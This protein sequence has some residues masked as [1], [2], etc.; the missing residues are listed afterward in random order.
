M[1]STCW[2]NKNHATNHCYEW[3][4]NKNRKINIFSLHVPP[5]SYHSRQWCQ[6]NFSGTYSINCRQSLRWWRWRQHITCLL[7]GNV[8]RW[9]CIKYYM[10]MIPPVQFGVVEENLYRGSVPVAANFPYLLGLKLKVGTSRNFFMSVVRL[11]III[12]TIWLT[13]FSNIYVKGDPVSCSG[14]ST[15]WTTP[16]YQNI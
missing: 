14:E 15:P 11:F 9:S 7:R 12:I 16:I 4:K 13:T 1:L 8:T 6:G 3:Q 5:S 10:E 2:G